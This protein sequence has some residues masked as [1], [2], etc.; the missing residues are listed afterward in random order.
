MGRIAI[1]EVDHRYYPLHGFRYR[2]NVDL[3]NAI[4]SD[5]DHLARSLLFC[6]EWLQRTDIAF[7]MFMVPGHPLSVYLIPRQSQSAFDDF[8]DFVTK[9]GFP[10]LSGQLIMVEEEEWNEMTIKVFLNIVNDH[11]FE[12]IVFSGCFTKMQDFLEFKLHLYYY[13]FH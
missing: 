11:I 3:E 1:D 12:V 6:I 7:N 8:T 10:E 5:L 2:L 13:G 9:P 4:Y